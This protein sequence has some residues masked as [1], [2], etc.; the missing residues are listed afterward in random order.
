MS[1]SPDIARFTTDYV[2]DQGARASASL[3]ILDTLSVLAAG[4]RDPGPGRLEGTLLPVTGQGNVPS[5]ISRSTFRQEDAALLLGMA[6]HALDYDD[7]CMLAICH[8]SAPVLSALLA[9]AI[10]R[11]SG[12][13]EFCDAF[14]IGTEVMIR[15]GQAIGFQHFELGFHATAT[16]GT[17]GATAALA[18]HSKADATSAQA[19]LAIA[20]SLMSGLRLNFGSMVKPLHVGI[21]AANATRALAW[22]QAGITAS[23]NDLFQEQG[24]LDAYS[25]RT[26]VRWPSGITLGAPPAIVAPGFERKRFSCCYM[27]HKV[28]ALGLEIAAH[29]I[30]LADIMTMSVSMPVGGTRPLNHPTPQTGRQAMFSLPYALVAAIADGAI[31]LGTFSDEAVQRPAIRARLADVLV[32]EDGPVL[33]TAGEIGDAPVAITLQMTNGTM[34]R[35]DRLHAPGSASDPLSSQELREKWTDCLTFARPDLPRHAA[36]GL[37]ERGLQALESE[38]ASDFFVEFLKTIRGEHAA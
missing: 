35:F 17:F 7:V 31:G 24:L 38:A 36:G 14:V 10:A 16:L 22:A 2:V 11:G 26:Q 33:A 1:T 21:A 28:I 25:G 23:S 19:A 12:G 34:R 5:P 15:L 4:C 8:P 29:G 37:Y 9:A 30:R 13:P 32:S 6:A 18:R 20:A 27:L 3:A